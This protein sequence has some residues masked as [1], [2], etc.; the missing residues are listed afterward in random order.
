MVVCGVKHLPQ[1]HEIDVS[2]VDHHLPQYAP[3]EFLDSG[4]Q[5]RVYKCKYMNNSWALMMILVSDD[6]NTSIDSVDTD[7]GFP[8]S[9][10]VARLKR[11]VSILRQCDS[12][13]LVRM[14][15]SDV[16]SLDIENLSILYFLEE[17]IDGTNLKQLIDHGLMELK[18]IQKLGVH[19]TLAIEALWQC[20]QFIHRDLKP[21]NIIRREATGDYVVIDVGLA[22]DIH[23]ASISRLGQIPGTALYLTPDQLDP[24]QKRQMDFRTDMFALGVTLYEA[25]TGRH[26][27][28]KS[29]MS[30][31]HL[32][33]AIRESTPIYPCDLREDLPFDLADIIM[34]LL[35]KKPHLRYR[36][37]RA[38]E[39]DLKNIDD[40]GLQ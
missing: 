34:R 11:E 19:V 20:N 12:P 36:T 21:S 10:A 17:Y 23:D 13:H 22:F 1:F 29:G 3:T 30:A 9:Q 25:S 5:K 15:P 24:G 8:S 33:E 4:G 14:G 18:E 40:G 32:T 26:P 16:N 38:L 39:N 35:A 37:T 27:F 6:P 28:F 31:A 7:F 2:I